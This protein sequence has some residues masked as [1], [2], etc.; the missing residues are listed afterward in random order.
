MS[1]ARRGWHDEPL[2]VVRYVEAKLFVTFESGLLERS[3]PNQMTVEH[4]LL[5]FGQPAIV[6]IEVNV[7]LNRSH[8]SILFIGYFYQFVQ[9]LALT[10]YLEIVDRVERDGR[11]NVGGRCS[12]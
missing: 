5:L 8:W 7:G 11:G 2:D 1:S 4:D 10:F 6:R 3:L 9:V 12:Q